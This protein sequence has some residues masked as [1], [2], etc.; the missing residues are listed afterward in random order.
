[1]IAMHVADKLSLLIAE[2]K[3]DVPRLSD[4][5]FRPY[6]SLFYNDLKVWRGSRDLTL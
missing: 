3:T 6:F 4:R 2:R 5:I 1:M